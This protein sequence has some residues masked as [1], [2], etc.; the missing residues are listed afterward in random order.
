MN[1]IGDGTPNESQYFAFA[2]ASDD[3]LHYGQMKRDFDHH[4][5]V[6]DMQREVAGLLL[7]KSIAVMQRSDLPPNVQPIPAVWSFGRKRAPDWSILKY[8]PASVHM[9]ANK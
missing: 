2:A 3:T 5:F 7:S 6:K 8:K 4:H 1:D 9:S